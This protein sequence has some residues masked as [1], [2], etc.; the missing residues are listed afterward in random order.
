MQGQGGEWCGQW[1]LRGQSQEEGSAVCAEDRLRG[2]IGD[3]M[4]GEEGSGAWQGG[5]CPEGTEEGRGCGCGQPVTQG[6]ERGQ[7]DRVG[8]RRE[9]GTACGRNGGML[10]AALSVG[11]PWLG[12]QM[13]E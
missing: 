12:A 3:S 5:S 6:E 11:V 1:G 2:K 13:P 9:Q 7:W 4:Q 10:V 8:V